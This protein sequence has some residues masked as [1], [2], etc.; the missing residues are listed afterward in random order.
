MQ[1]CGG[2]RKELEKELANGLHWRYRSGMPL[3]RGSEI[4]WGLKVWRKLDP[5]SLVFLSLLPSFGHVRPE[6]APAPSTVSGERQ[7]EAE[8]GLCLR[9]S[10]CLSVA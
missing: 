10:V 3:D 2:C 8:K 7:P 4:R 9:I 1:W 5:D 6:T